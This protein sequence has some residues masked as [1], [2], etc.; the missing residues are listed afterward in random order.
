MQFHF[1]NINP[2][3]ISSPRTVPAVAVIFN[4]ARNMR[5]TIK[6]RDV[7]H[8]YRTIKKRSPI[9]G[10]KFWVGNTKVGL[11]SYSEIIN[12]V[13]EKRPKKV[14]ALTK[15]WNRLSRFR[16]WIAKKMYK[17][18]PPRMKTL[19][20]KFGRVE[21]LLHKNLVC[22]KPRLERRYGYLVYPEGLTVKAIKEKKNNFWEYLKHGDA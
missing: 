22:L 16:V 11:P 6:K 12:A 9:L 10:S 15:A 5:G 14:N 8:L 13:R 17:K 18:L 3:K 1:C 2:L 20:K 7:R 19:V 4:E 21:A